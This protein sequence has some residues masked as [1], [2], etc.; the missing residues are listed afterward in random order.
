MGEKI[1]VET[2]QILNKYFGMALMLSIKPW[3]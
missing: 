3:L 2:D 1:N